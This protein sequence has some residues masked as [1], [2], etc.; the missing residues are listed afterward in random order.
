VA[1]NKID[2]DDAN[3]DRVK[4]QLADHGVV[5]ED[6]GGDVVSVPVSAKTGDG[7]GHLLEMILLVSD[8]GEPRANPDR[9]GEAVVIDSQLQRGQGPVAS[10]L[11]Q[12]GTLRV[13]DHFVVGALAGRVRALFDDRGHRTAEVTPG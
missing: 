1:I 3:P 4:Q 5:V 13:Q 11:V 7:V 2:R 10:V 12:E 8:L 6:F 9:P